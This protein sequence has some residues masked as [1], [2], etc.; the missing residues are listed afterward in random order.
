MKLTNSAILIPAYNAAQTIKAVINSVQPYFNRIIVVNDGSEDN[1]GKIALDAGSEV[2]EHAWNRGKGA[3]LRT[4][5][6]YL[7]RDN[8]KWIMTMDADGQH[9]AA[10]IP[11]LVNLM[12]N[13]NKKEKKYNTIPWGIIIGSR[14]TSH[15]K[16]PSYRYY[17]NKVGKII[18]TKITG[19]DLKDTQSGFRI[20][21]SELLKHLSLKSN[22][23][24]LETEIIFKTIKMGYGIH[25]VP[26]QVIYPENERQKTNFRPIVDTYRISIM[27]L[28]KMIIPKF[29]KFLISKILFFK[30]KFS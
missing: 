3:A 5:F 7:L 14:F 11:N 16:I 13:Q 24:E 8:C 26:I 1:T 29:I 27:V 28:L 23:F 4:G 18:L 30:N 15:N 12:N 20:Y 17:P 6:D 21:R 2:L 9:N 25:F 10:D 22:R 19:K